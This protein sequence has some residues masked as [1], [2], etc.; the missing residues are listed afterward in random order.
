MKFKVR[1]TSW[2]MRREPTEGLPK[3]VAFEITGFKLQDYA[4]CTVFALMS[5]GEQL[6]LDAKVHQNKVYGSNLPDKWTVQALNSNGVSV[7]ID[8]ET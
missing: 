8:V 5:D 7:L 3:V 6:T 2:S 1:E 4:S